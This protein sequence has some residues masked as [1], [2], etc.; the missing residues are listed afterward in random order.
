MNRVALRA[1]VWALT[2]VPDN[3]L[4]DCVLACRVANRLF[5]PREPSDNDRFREA[6]AAGPVRGQVFHLLD[7]LPMQH[8]KGALVTECVLIVYRREQLLMINFEGARDCRVANCIFLLR[9]PPMRKTER[10]KMREQ[11]NAWRPRLVLE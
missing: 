6:C 5:P 11:C 1:L 8:L 7:E 2:R 9:A 4:G 3:V 10:E